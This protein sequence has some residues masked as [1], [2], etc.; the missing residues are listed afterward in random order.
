[1][2]GGLKPLNSPS[3]WVRQ[4]LNLTIGY[5]TLDQSS[6]SRGAEKFHT[7]AAAAL[8]GPTN[9]LNDACASANDNE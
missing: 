8:S 4:W 9:R 1:M 6:H 7:I 3:L 5:E 2:G